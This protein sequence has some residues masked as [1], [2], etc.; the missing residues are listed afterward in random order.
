MSL[1]VEMVNDQQALIMYLIHIAKTDQEHY[2]QVLLET[3]SHY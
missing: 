3:N 2:Q 1:K